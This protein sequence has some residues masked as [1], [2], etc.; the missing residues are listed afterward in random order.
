MAQLAD[1]L[2]G[3]ARGYVDRPAI[4]NTELKGV[5]TFTLTSSPLQVVDSQRR[6]N[7]T[8]DGQTDASIPN[9]AVTMFEALEKVGL[10]LE[11]G[12]KHLEPVLVIDHMEPLVS[13]N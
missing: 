2:H 6:Q 7:P 8:A 5:C 4:D 13:E 1:T 3:A 9:G 10:H 11:S 12:Q